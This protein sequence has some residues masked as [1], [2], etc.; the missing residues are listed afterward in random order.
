MKILSKK[1]EQNILDIINNKKINEEKKVSE[2]KKEIYKGKP[3]ERTVLVRYSA[4]K[5]IIYQD[6]K[7]H[8]VKSTKNIQCKAQKILDKLQPDPNLINKIRKESEKKRD[9]K[10]KVIINQDI[11]EKIMSYENSDDIYENAIYLLLVTGR[12]IIELIESEF[13]LSKKKQYKNYILADGIKKRKDDGNGCS[14]IPLVNNKKVMKKIKD[15]KNKIKYKKN[16]E[17]FKRLLLRKI[18]A[19]IDQNMKTHSLR[20]IYVMY[21]YKFRNEK[22]EKVNSFIMSNL[23][24][25]N[26]DSSLNYTGYELNF[27]E[28][29][30]N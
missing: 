3:T 28:D 21:L 8:T 15:F 26:I 24:H 23:C 20:G 30:I 6:K 16:I 14:F 1:T 29:I 13:Y 17:S 18:K 22:N 2:I 27:D 9:Q 12:R 11:I 19:K 5:K 10:K 4:I 7:K 25:Q